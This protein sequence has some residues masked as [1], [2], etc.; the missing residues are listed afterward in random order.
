MKAIERQAKLHDA[1]HESHE[2]RK[3]KGCL[4]KSCATFVPNLAPT[5][6]DV[7]VSSA[8]GWFHHP[9]QNPPAQLRLSGSH[10]ATLMIARPVKVNVCG[11][12]VTVNGEFT[13]ADVFT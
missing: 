10:C 4:N 2:N 3:R 11:K 13:L 1:K 5:R 6:T 9:Q 8:G 12:P 7:H